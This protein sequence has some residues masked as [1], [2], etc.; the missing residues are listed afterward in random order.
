MAILDFKN[1]LRQ[2]FEYGV[3]NCVLYFTDS[4]IAW[5]GVTKI[6]QKVNSD[7]TSYYL[8]GQKLIDRP[9][10][11][12]YNAIV[13]SFT[14]PSNI[15]S[16]KILAISYITR[17]NN[18]II[19]H[20]VYY[21]KFILEE[22]SSTTYSDEVNTSKFVFSVTSTPTRFDNSITTSHVQIVLSNNTD[23]YKLVT[24]TLY[25]TVT[26]EPTLLYPKDIASLVDVVTYSHS[27]IIIDYG[28]G[29]WTAIGDDTILSKIS[30]S[31]GFEIDHPMAKIIAADTYTLESG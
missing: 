2:P 21:P 29:S 4:V 3:Q 1:K 17:T 19:L 9:T 24:N 30:F 18:N 16:K 12:E 10:I 25:G 7:D 14:L 11:I 6:E 15:D 13:E 22:W 31:D 26:S 20:I 28:D 5:N 27:L 23:L 8:D